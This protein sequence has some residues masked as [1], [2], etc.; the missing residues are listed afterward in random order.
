VP[1][2]GK[3]VRLVGFGHLDLADPREARRPAGLARNA[4]NPV[5]GRQKLRH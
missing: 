2:A 3:P 5:T 4:P 1:A